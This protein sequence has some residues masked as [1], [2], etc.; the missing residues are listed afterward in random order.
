MALTALLFVTGLLG[1]SS[2]SPQSFGAMR[3]ENDTDFDNLLGAL[4]EGRITNG[5][6]TGACVESGGKPHA[7][8]AR[9]G[10]DEEGRIDLNDQF[11]M[12]IYREAD[13]LVFIYSQ[14]DE[15]FAAQYVLMRGACNDQWFFCNEVLWKEHVRRAA[16]L[17]VAPGRP[18]K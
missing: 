16:T 2:G 18:A 15:I 1:C 4:R 3:G 9:A 14:N 6:S 7:A 13:E 10:R 8:I 5:S 11:V 17:R 12:S